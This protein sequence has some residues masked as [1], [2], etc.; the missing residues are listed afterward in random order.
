LGQTTQAN[1][2]HANLEALC[3]Q[4]AATLSD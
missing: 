3:Q 2:V 1:A 4:Q